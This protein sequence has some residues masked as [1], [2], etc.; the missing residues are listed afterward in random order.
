MFQ[1]LRTRIP[2]CERAVLKTM[3][4][5]ALAR[6]THRAVGEYVITRDDFMQ[7]RDFEDKICNAFN[8]VDMHTE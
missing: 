3:A 7:A 4:A 6:E 5:H 1:F 8:Y 2:G